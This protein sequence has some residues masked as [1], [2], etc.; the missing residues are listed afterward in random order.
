MQFLSL[1]AKKN[2][3]QKRKKEK[4]PVDVISASEGSTL[5]K[6][7]QVVA[8]EMDVTNTKTSDPEVDTST[9]EAVSPTHAVCIG[10]Q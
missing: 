6:C 5:D 4:L 7:E 3:I 1:E 8:M 9:A 10:G 2:L